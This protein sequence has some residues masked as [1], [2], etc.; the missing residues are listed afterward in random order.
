MAK[1]IGKP[2]VVLTATLELTKHELGALDALAGY[3]TD[4]FLEVFYKHMG[5]AYLEK[6]EE[7]LRSLFRSVRENVPRMFNRAREA[8][9]AFTKD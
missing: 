3:G 9:K 7:G 2:K 5:K 4:E 6:H 8:E 1:I